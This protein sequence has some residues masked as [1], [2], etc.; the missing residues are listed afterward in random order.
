MV[1]CGSASEQLCQSELDAC[2]AV[3]GAAD[4][5]TETA[6]LTA[7]VSDVLGRFVQDLGSKVLAGVQSLRSE[8]AAP[9]TAKLPNPKN[10]ELSEKE[11]N[12]KELSALYVA[13]RC[14]PLHG[15]HGLQ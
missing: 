10:E 7:A 15:L 4:S 13:S 1:L 5:K 6:Y 3:W 12:W 2:S 11:R 14:A 8:A 9:A